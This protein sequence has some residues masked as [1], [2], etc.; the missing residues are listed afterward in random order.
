LFA[1][2]GQH[3]AEFRLTDLS[4]QLAVVD[5]HHQVALCNGAP[6]LEIEAR[7][8]T[9]GF[10]AQFDLFIRPDRTRRKDA[11]VQG[12]GRNDDAFDL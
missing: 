5:L 6:F 9:G 2:L 11:I 10:A 8:L 1:I 4:L 12:Y 7:D 3:N